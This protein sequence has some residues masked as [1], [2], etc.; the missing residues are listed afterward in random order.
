MEP[1]P[2]NAGVGKHGRSRLLDFRVGLLLVKGREMIVPKNGNGGSAQSAEISPKSTK[3]FVEGK[4]HAAI[5]G[6]FREIELS[7]TV[8]HTGRVEV[9]ESVRG[10]DT[11]GPWSNP[12]FHGDVEAYACYAA[13]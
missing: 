5:R 7:P 10:Y 9:D 11:S 13:E 6:P 4:I 3:V 1:D 12:D 2:S 8:S